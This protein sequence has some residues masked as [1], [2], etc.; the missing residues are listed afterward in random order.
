MVDCNERA[1]LH[2]RHINS[3]TRF[4]GGGCL[5][6]CSSVAGCGCEN[7]HSSKAYALSVCFLFIFH[8]AAI[9]AHNLKVTG[10]NPVPAT[11]FLKY[12]RWLRDGKMI[13]QAILWFTS[14]PRQHRSRKTTFVHNRV[15]SHTAH[16]HSPT[17][18]PRKI[19]VGRFHDGYLIQ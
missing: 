16:A 14:T 7:S 8:L 10:S 12:I 17:V 2:Q 18:N 11:K 3:R 6:T 1:G 9:W 4:F 5:P 19:D 15:R 13:P